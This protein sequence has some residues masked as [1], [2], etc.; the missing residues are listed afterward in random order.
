MELPHDEEVVVLQAQ[1][2]RPQDRINHQLQH[3]NIPDHQPAIHRVAVKLPPFWAD[4]PS[5]WFAQADSQFVISNIANEVTK[6]HYVVS[7]LDARIAA[8]VEDIIT[9]PPATNQFTYLR[10][11][12]IERL[13]ASEEQRIQRLLSEEELGDRKPSQFLRHLRHLAGTTAMQDNLL[14]QLWLRRLPSNVQAILTVQSDVAVDK[15]ADIADKIIEVSPITSYNQVHVTSAEKCFP[16]K[17][18][19]DAIEALSKQVA[20]LTTQTQRFRTRSRGRQSSRSKSVT[21]N[22]G[23]SRLCWYH[24]KFGR[25]AKKCISP[26]NFQGN[27]NGSS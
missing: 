22:D 27:F 2:A 19:F 4:R 24:E 5:L 13:S 9:N 23:C 1:N 11:K 25:K 20:E 26:C 6:F 16:E 10:S 21:S 7:Q 18:L 15:L 8:E 3:H 12:L 17:H 14:K